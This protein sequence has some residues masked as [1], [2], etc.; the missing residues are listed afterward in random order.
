[1]FHPSPMPAFDQDNIENLCNRKSIQTNISVY[2]NSESRVNGY[3]TKKGASSKQYSIPANRDQNLNASKCAIIASSFYMYI[4]QIR[5]WLS[6]NMFF[7]VQ[8]A[9]AM[10]VWNTL[11]IDFL[12]QNFKYTKLVHLFK[13]YLFYRDGFNIVWAKCRHWGEGKH[14]LRH[15]SFEKNIYS[16]PTTKT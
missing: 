8:Q 16:F 2:I 6:L 3:I 4:L 15:I 12:L 1:M 13:K 11:F 10:M 14:Y 9:T 7:N 5:T